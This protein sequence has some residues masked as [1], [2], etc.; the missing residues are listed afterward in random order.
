MAA[1][2]AHILKKKS[3]ILALEKYLDKRVTVMLASGVEVRG[4]LKGFDN[5]V[6]LLLADAD[7]W[8]VDA[9]KP[10][11]KLGTTVVRGRHVVE[12][13]S[14]DTALLASNPFL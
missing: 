4:L 14:S 5:N 1:E 13:F 10:L 9:V 11:R 7:M 3:C 2:V 12:V 8:S 6:S